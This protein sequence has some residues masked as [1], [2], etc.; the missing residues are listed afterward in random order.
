[1]SSSVVDSWLDRL[2]EV[3]EEQHLS[4]PVAS[5][6]AA[7][8]S[9]KRKAEE[10][11]KRQ[12]KRQASED[13]E[14]YQALESRSLEPFPL[15]PGSTRSE[16]SAKKRKT[17]E[18]SSNAPPSLTALSTRESSRGGQTSSKRNQDLIQ[19]DLIYAFPAITRID[20]LKLDQVPPRGL[21]LYNYLQVASHPPYLPGSLKV[22]KHPSIS[23]SVPELTCAQRIIQNQP[24]HKLS[25]IA[26]CVWEEP[27]KPSIFNLDA[28]RL[29]NIFEEEVQ[30]I[31]ADSHQCHIDNDAED[32]WCNKVVQPTLNLA[33]K[34]FSGNSRC[35]RPWLWESVQTCKIDP[36]FEP[37]L[38]SSKVDIKTDFALTLRNR[39]DPAVEKI[40]ERM[41]YKKLNRG[42]QTPPTLSHVVS[43]NV[44]SRLPL[45]SGVEVKKPSADGYNAEVQCHIWSSANVN[46]KHHLHSQMLPHPRLEP[47]TTHQPPRGASTLL[48]NLARGWVSID[49]RVQLRPRTPE[50]FTEAGG[51]ITLANSS[52]ASCVVTTATISSS[53]VVE[54]DPPRPTI[55]E[56]FDPDIGIAVVGSSWRFF[57]VY[58]DINHGQASENPPIG[59]NPVGIV[60]PVATADTTD[61]SELFKLLKILVAVITYENN[62][63]ETLTGEKSGSAMVGLV[64]KQEGDSGIDYGV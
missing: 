31:L 9:R 18:T 21:A 51:P 2:S 40:Y 34:M 27:G 26:R 62:M 56:Q 24:A 10:T 20:R 15:T 57:I 7:P 52:P 59:K 38:N 33:L 25:E 11:L 35:R 30:A 28:D 39:N 3:E 13:L 5:V 46:K 49:S 12:L 17:D 64:K 45:F 47:S 41:G 44:L 1:M 14:N 8:V 42:G 43:S 19:S 54:P 61:L 50:R 48:T 63:L 36:D 29:Q 32:G 4:T 58:H 22:S 16:R 37:L 55:V 60:G 6:I 23:I 53:S